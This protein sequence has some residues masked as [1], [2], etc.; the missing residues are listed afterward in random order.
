MANELITVQN[1]AAWGN[2]VKTWAT[3]R[4]YFDEDYNGGVPPR[5]TSLD[6]L[7][8]QCAWAQV[9]IHIPARV[10]ALHIT[11]SNLETLVLNL[12]AAEM[13]TV[14]ESEVKKRVY[15]VPEFYSEL[16]FG[17][18][19]PSVSADDAVRLHACRVGDYVIGQCV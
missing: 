8:A 6:E 7:K 5:P 18:A 10:K 19:Q 1:A 4:N 15:P 3:G 14:G 17:G 13:V 9:G 12:P 11:S 16:A 2:L